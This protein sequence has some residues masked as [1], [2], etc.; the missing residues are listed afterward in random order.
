MGRAGRL[1]EALAQEELEQALD[2]ALR[3]LRDFEGIDVEREEIAPEAI[4]LR[5]ET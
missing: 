1:A 3:N 5:I 2:D 4:E